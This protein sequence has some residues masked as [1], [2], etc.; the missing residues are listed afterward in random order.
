[1][2]VMPDVVNRRRTRIA[3]RH[4]QGNLRTHRFVVVRDGA[5]DHEERHDPDDRELTKLILRVHPP[6]TCGTN[7][8]DRV[9]PASEAS[10]KV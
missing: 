6:G 1:M 5:G 4:S 2:M 10:E 3:N 7:G 9:P 8:A